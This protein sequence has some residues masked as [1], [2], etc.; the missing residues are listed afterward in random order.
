MEI[1]KFHADKSNANG[2]ISAIFAGNA[3]FDLCSEQTLNY[4][5]HIHKL[6]LHKQ[7]FFEIVG[8]ILKNHFSLGSFLKTGITV[9]VKFA[10]G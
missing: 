8:P 7:G 6:Y 10:F 1:W 2:L 3:R 5:N 9:L 4:Q